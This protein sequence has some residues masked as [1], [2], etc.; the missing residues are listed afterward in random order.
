MRPMQ[1]RLPLDH[2]ST[3]RDR[4]SSPFSWAAHG[5]AV[6]YALALALSGIVLIVVLHGTPKPANPPFTQFYLAGSWAHTSG[7]VEARAGHALAVRVGITNHTRQTQTYTLQPAL[8]GTTRWAVQEVRLP[9]G[10]AW[11]GILRG[12][13]TMDNCLQRLVIQLGTARNSSVASSLVLWVRGRSAVAPA[14]AAGHG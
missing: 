13:V 11:S 4:K 14:C 1:H 7:I 2:P 8:D 3:T 9:A 5:W 10:R 6:G 12:P